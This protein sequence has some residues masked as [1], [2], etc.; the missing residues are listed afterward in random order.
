MSSKTHDYEQ[1]AGEYADLGLAGTQLL[2]FRDIETLLETYAGPITSALDYGCGAGRSTR[3]LKNLGLNVIGVDVNLDMLDQARSKDGPGVYHQIGSGTIPFEDG[4]F[5]LVFSSFVLLEVSSL[6]E[7]ERI[8]GEM[9]RVLRP[10]GTI[11]FVTASMEASEGEW[12]SLSYAF[13]EN[14]KPLR[15]GD[16]VKLHILDV[17]VVLHDYYWTDDDYRGAAE[18]AG[19]RVVA[20]HQPLGSPDDGIAWRDEATMSPLSIYVLK[21]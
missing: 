1:Q 18:R 8:L 3:F 10:D 14:D 4:E 7:I 16:T 11:V 21:N 19:L 9:R 12:V 15:S 17:D 20:L 2:A 5:D 13:P 6:D